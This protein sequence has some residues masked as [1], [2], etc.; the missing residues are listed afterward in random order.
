MDNNSYIIMTIIYLVVTFAIYFHSI[1]YSYAKTYVHYT[2]LI[3]PLCIVAFLYISGNK[4]PNTIESS[5]SFMY[6]FVFLYL[7]IMILTFDRAGAIEYKFIKRT[8]FL[9]LILSSIMLLYSNYTQ[10]YDFYTHMD[11]HDR[12]ESLL[13][14]IFF[15]LIRFIFLAVIFFGALKNYHNFS[16]S[17]NF[18]LYTFNSLLH[19]FMPSY[20]VIH[21]LFITHFVVYLELYIFNDNILVKFKERS[22]LFHSMDCMY[23]ILDK[24]NQVKEIEHSEK[25]TFFS[26]EKYRFISYFEMM[27]DIRNSQ[28]FQVIGSNT[29]KLNNKYIEQH[30]TELHHAHKIVIFRNITDE[31]I[32]SSDII[33]LSLVDHVT[34][35]K[36]RKALLEDS[37]RINLSDKNVLYIDL[38]KLKYINDTYS[39]STGDRALQFIAGHLTRSYKDNDGNIYRLG[40]DE[41]LVITRKSVEEIIEITENSK[42]FINIEKKPV[43]L[44]YSLG[45]VKCADYPGVNLE[46]IIHFSDEAMYL[47]KKSNKKY[48]IY[49]QDD[50]N[51]MLEST[52]SE[53]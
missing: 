31:Y 49:G 25:S 26:F 17:I 53:S 22:K 23:L 19:L 2:V 16:Q 51:E 46:N 52:E 39:H 20:S 36:N 8:I 48:I 33:E 11:L 44:S 21:Y 43:D 10:D 27:K 47:C 29:Y 4:Y 28:K 1:K 5:L 32:Y 3:V 6:P 42:L 30:T 41:F 7:Y 13:F 14:K 18:V 38:N 37:Y 24:N 12:S 34:K 35:L 45:I 15:F 50:L 40:G 9:F